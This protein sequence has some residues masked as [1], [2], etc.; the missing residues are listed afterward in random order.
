MAWLPA[1]PGS[2]A[3]QLRLM[4][5]LEDLKT[6]AH[7]PAQFQRL[8][9]A[10]L[11]LRSLTL[12]GVTEIVKYHTYRNDD[13]HK[14]HRKNILPLQGLLILLHYSMTQTGYFTCKK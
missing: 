3:K 6:P 11:P 14:S 13:V 7:T 1:R 2:S 5:G 10:I 12:K 9:A 8:V 4:G